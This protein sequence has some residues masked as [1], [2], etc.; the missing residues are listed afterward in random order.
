[1]SFLHR[2][3]YLSPRGNQGFK[4]T[5]PGRGVQKTNNN[6]GVHGH[7]AGSCATVYERKME[8]MHEDPFSTA[9]QR[10]RQ[11]QVRASSLSHRSI[12]E[13]FSVATSQDDMNFFSRFFCF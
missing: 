13:E 4:W 3:V 6:R 5:G 12:G 11:L 2:A 7:F 9:L 8:F 1:M 10:L